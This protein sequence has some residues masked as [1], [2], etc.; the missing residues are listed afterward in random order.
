MSILVGRKTRVICQGLTGRQGRYHAERMLRYGTQ[1]VAGVTPG[2]GGSEVLGLPIY[3]LVQDAV[4]ETDAD[5]SIIFVPPASAVDAIMEAAKAGI[6]LVVCITEGIPVQDMLRLKAALSFYNTRLIGP[7]SPGIITPGECKMGIMPGQIHQPGIIGIVSRS[8]TLTYEAV[9]QTSKVGLGQSTVV[10]IGGDPV[11]GLGF[12]DC[13]EMFE[14]DRKTKGIILV[15][16]IGGSEEEEAAAYIQRHVRKPVVA[17]VAGI[18][19]PRNRR[20]GHAGAIVSRAQGSAR[21]KYAALEEAGV[22]VVFNP[23]LMGAKMLEY[24]RG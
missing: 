16:E 13:L 18:S 6:G 22:M 3:D 12:I 21:S 19:A 11:H 8:G 2:K 20:M 4:D 7:N 1:L 23:A 15:G 5:A 10:G 17:Y 9:Q 24:F 14:A